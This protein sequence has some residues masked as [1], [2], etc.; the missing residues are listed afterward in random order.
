MIRYEVHLEPNPALAGAVEA[1]MRGEHIPAIMATGCFTRARFERTESGGYRTVYEAGSRAD[2]E[3]YMEDHFARFRGEFLAR[4][5][6]GVAPS[7][8]LWTELEAW[9]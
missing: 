8:E 2:F 9:T 3:R 1:Y 6:T 5:P 4:F 7:R